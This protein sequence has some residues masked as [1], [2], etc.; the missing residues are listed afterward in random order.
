[1]TTRKRSFP[2]PTKIDSG[3]SD[4]RFNPSGPSPE[5]DGELKGSGALGQR[6]AWDT[7]RLERLGNVDDTTLGTTGGVSNGVDPV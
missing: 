1:M 5:R 4:G 2:T 3:Q 6:L 7:P